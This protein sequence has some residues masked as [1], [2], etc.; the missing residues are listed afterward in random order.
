MLNLDTLTV[1]VDQELLRIDRKYSDTNKT[2]L[3]REFDSLGIAC[4][5]NDVTLKTFTLI[6]IHRKTVGEVQECKNS[7]IKVKAENL[8]LKKTIV[9]LEDELKDK[10]L[11]LDIMQ[12]KSVL[13]NLD[14]DQLQLEKATLH[15][16]LKSMRKA[17]QNKENVWEKRLQQLSN[18]NALLRDQMQNNIGKYS[19]ESDIIA[20]T[21][22]KYKRNEEIY[23][24]IIEK[25]QDNNKGLLEEILN[26]KEE[27]VLALI[28][29]NGN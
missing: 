25:L 16:D 11:T 23:K 27:V 12:K 15:K 6:N 26:L 2:R 10:A 8:E 18:E 3:L 24:D 22:T 4:E 14:K 13:T 28:S 5:S 7:L 1:E 20:S 21:I 19:S 9:K 17:F 29:K